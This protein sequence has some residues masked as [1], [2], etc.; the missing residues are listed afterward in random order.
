MRVVLAGGGTGGHAYPAIAVAEA[1]REQ[2]GAEIIYYGTPGGPERTIAEQHGIPFQGVHASQ[3]RG[4][5][6][7]MIR[8]A[9]NLAR[10][11]REASRHLR[12]DRPGAVFA[13]G[14]YAAAPVGRAA[15]RSGIP[16]VV[17]LPDVKPGWAVRFLERYAATVACSVEG[18]LGAL[19]ARSRVV[20]GYPVRRQFREATREQGLRRFGLEAGIPTLLVA[21]G[22][23][24]SHHLNSVIAGE[25]RDLLSRAQIVHIAGAAE[26]PW[27]ARERERLPAWQ[28]ARYH[29]YAYTDE[30]AWAMAAADLAVT[31][32][33]A[34]ILGELPA[35]RLPAVIVPGRFSDQRR[36]ADFL[37][38]RG[39]ALMLPEREIDA[40]PDL[41]RRLLGDPGE[42]ERLGE[43]MSALARP[44]A[45][46]RLAEIV[47]EAAA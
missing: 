16:L 47:R 27:L 8:G 33:G 34:S 45:A 28:R 23:L 26:E 39:A 13:T 15:R 7:R 6:A 14:G 4:S 24:G 38:E 36:N 29:L 2:P 22:S 1:L 46:A 11:S 10:G 20:T 37:V 12:R 19:R 17:F 43:A 25:L 35:T 32:G 18:S 9:W 30:I 31:R 3:L 42:R 44:D 5:P 40:L 21:G 41:V